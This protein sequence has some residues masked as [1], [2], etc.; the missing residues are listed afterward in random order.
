M[1]PSSICHSSLIE[2]KVKEAV[3]AGITVVASAGNNALDAS[4]FVP[5]NVSGV[6]TVGACDE[7][8]VVLSS[9]NYGDD[10]DW[11]VNASATSGAAATVSVTAAPG[12][13]HPCSVG[14]DVVCS[15]YR[16]PAGL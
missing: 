16:G 15:G 5:A 11:Y 2:A 4:N 14:G 1:Y 12:E 13:E 10:V 6:I 9:S 3:K 8:G 7:D